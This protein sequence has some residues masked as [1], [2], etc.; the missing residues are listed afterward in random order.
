MRNNRPKK[1]TLKNIFGK[2]RL[3]KKFK[4]KK[5]NKSKRAKK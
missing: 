3:G 5:R 4:S 2:A 1:P